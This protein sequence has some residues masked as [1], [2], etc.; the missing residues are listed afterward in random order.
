MRV[1]RPVC[2]SSAND[3]HTQAFSTT[4]TFYAYN[5]SLLTVH[6]VSCDKNRYERHNHMH[7]PPRSRALD[8]DFIRLSC[9]EKWLSKL[10][11]AINT[12][13]PFYSLHDVKSQSCRCLC[14]QQ[15]TCKFGAFLL[16]I[17]STTAKICVVFRDLNDA[18]QDI[19]QRN[20][21][22]I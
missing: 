18:I 17:A 21:L 13:K 8:G 3:T 9:I 11:F 15:E 1:V 12:S 19:I 14:A 20:R 7:K 16:Q 4:V 6:K 10:H 22:Q 5:C 2:L